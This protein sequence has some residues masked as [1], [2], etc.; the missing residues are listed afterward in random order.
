MCSA[1]AE[2]LK[3]SIEFEFWFNFDKNVITFIETKN[4]AT[5][6]Q[7][8]RVL[9]RHTHSL[10]F[11]H[12]V[13]SICKMA[14]VN[15]AGPMLNTWTFFFTLFH[16]PFARSRSPLHR[17]SRSLHWHRVLNVS[18]FFT[19]FAYHSVLFFTSGLVWRKWH[20]KMSNALYWHGL[21]S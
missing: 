5:S 17:H 2:R 15:R 19:Q 20:A 16:L 1:A 8:N 9:P 18:F 11:Q 7:Q 3:K 13:I 21:S 6:Q 12:T 10:E 14:I 4:K